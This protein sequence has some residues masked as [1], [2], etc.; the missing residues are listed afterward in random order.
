MLMLLKRIAEMTE[1]LHLLSL[2]K[3]ARSAFLRNVF[4]KSLDQDSRGKV[5]HLDASL[6]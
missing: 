4:V 1:W 5:S 2:A 3:R 6:C